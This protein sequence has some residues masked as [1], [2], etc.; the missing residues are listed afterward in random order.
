MVRV[1]FSSS[2]R[3]SLGSVLWLL[4]RPRHFVQGSAVVSPVLLDLEKLTVGG[5]VK[6]LLPPSRQVKKGR[7]SC[8]RIIHR[9]LCISS[10][11]RSLAFLVWL[12]VALSE[13]VAVEPGWVLIPEDT[14]RRQPP[15]LADPEPGISEEP[16]VEGNEA[17]GHCSARLRGDAG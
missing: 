16:K 11:P 7:A 6:A 17:A 2:R 5:P 9:I 8:S 4:A 10:P 13:M 3:R 15:A 12:P 1:S 14:R